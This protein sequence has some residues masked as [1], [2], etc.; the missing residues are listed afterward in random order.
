MRTVGDAIFQ[1]IFPA[2]G[3]AEFGFGNMLCN[4]F[5]I[6]QT[7]TEIGLQD[8]HGI[9]ISV[10]A[11]KPYCFCW[12]GVIQLVGQGDAEVTGIAVIRLGHVYLRLTS[13]IAIL[14]E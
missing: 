13:N 11:G 10:D 12:N 3:T 14:V 9:Y 6:I 1:K 4:E 2:V 8:E 5:C 7:N